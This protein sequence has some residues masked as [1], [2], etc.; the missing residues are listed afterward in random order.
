MYLQNYLA[1]GN[2]NVIMWVV[3]SVIILLTLLNIVGCT[4]VKCRKKADF[5]FPKMTE[6][7]HSRKALIHRINFFLI[8]TKNASAINR[9]D[10]KRKSEI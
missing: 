2:Q 6:Q 10:R 9:A 3:L 8:N 7:Y 4:V 5:E 1:L